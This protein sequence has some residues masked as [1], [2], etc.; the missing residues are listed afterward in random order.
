MSDSQ[1]VANAGIA[2]A[3]IV[4]DAYDEVPLVG[5]LAAEDAWDNF[6][7]DAQGP[8]A[9]RIE[10]I[11]PGF[12]EA[13]RGEL[14]SDQEFIALLW[15]HRVNIADLLNGLFEAYERKAATDAE[16]LRHAEE[17]LKSLAIPFTRHGRDFEDAA[18]SAD[19]ILIDLFLGLQ[20]NDADR[21]LTVD[22]LKAAIAR[23]DD[24][25]GPPAI[26]LMSQVPTIAEQAPEFRKDANLHASS[27]R[28]LHKPKL[29]EVGRVEGLIVT[30]SLHRKDSKALSAFVDTWEECAVKAA[31][32]AA[33]A[34]RKIDIDDLTHIRTM[35]LRLE[36]VNTSSYMLDVFDRVLQYEIE[37]FVEVIDAA[38]PLDD[39]ADDPAPLVISNDRDTY[40]I[41]ERTLFVN[42]QRRAHATGAIWPLTFGDII[43]PRGGVAI[44]PRGF[45]TGR[46]DLVFFVASPECD[47]I[48]PGGLTTALLVAG[49]LIE[50]GMTSR[51]LPVRGDNTPVLTLP[52]GERFQIAWDFG[53][54]RAVTL[55][56]SKSLLGEDGD[57]VVLRRLRD[58]SALALR[59]Q[60]LTN[61]GRVGEIAPIPRSFR[62]KAEIFYPLSDSTLERLDL[63]DD[64]EIEGNIL[65]PRNTDATVM[66]LDSA[67]EPHLSTAL[68]EIDVKRL[69]AGSQAQVALL[70]QQSQLRKLFRSGFQWT[71]QPLK[72]V[73]SA[74][75]LKDNEPEPEDHKKPK[76]EKV[77]TIATDCDFKVKLGSK[78]RQAGLVF[79]IT[80]VD[81][82]KS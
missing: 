8:D 55:A 11:Y 39:M 9:A 21:K 78:L 17:A 64:M 4:D 37:A 69:A 35:L 30:L 5:E 10:A 40:A 48:R 43:G 54:L 7:Y 67:C 60:L 26:I 71:G 56:R 34:M 1:I 20:Q 13:D 45:F 25:A 27:F 73:Q 63:P 59:Q 47:L 3:I 66:I 58:V 12:G 2:K 14:R 15:L 46:D 68:L 32:T 76:L 52:N 65:V 79:Q 38:I 29:G 80:V 28:H 82:D 57:A 16:F 42:P 18:V 49:R 36:G 6:F 72:A 53:D 23:R 70:Q 77:G 75:L 19:L 50:I 33:K 74:N 31:E 44:K 51:I 62:F 24:G 81:V 41:I 22:K 61:M